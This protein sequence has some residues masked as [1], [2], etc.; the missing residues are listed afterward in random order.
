MACMRDTNIT[1]FYQGGTTCKWKFLLYTK[2]ALGFEQG[3]HMQVK[4]SALY[5]QALGFEQ[6]RRMQVGRMQVGLSLKIDFIMTF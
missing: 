1:I 2:Q 3:Y 4:V 6:E 5:K